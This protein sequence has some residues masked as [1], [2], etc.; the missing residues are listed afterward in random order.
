MLV[1]K[2]DFYRV[3]TRQ[4]NRKT[5]QIDTDIRL[6][7]Y[8]NIFALAFGYDTLEIYFEEKGKKKHVKYI[9]L[10]E[11]MSTREQAVI[12]YISGILK[13]MQELDNLIG[14]K[15]TKYRDSAEERLSYTDTDYF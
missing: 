13:Y 9:N 12:D 2:K 10:Y 6:T 5:S 1:I 15:R 14:N 11:K 7:M 8:Y 3:I 4:L